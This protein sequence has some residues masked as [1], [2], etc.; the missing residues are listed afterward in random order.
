MT[1]PGLLTTW[2][3]TLL[4]TIGTGGAQSPSETPEQHAKRYLEL[5]EEAAA[6]R[7]SPDP[8]NAAARLDQQQDDVR[9]AW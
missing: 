8:T 3:L 6:R 2:T 5:L 9:R 4:C 1:S 7:T